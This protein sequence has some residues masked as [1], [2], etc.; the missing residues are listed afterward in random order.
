M[1]VPTVLSVVRLASSAS[2]YAWTAQEVR[3]LSA[4]HSTG[5][6]RC[7][8]RDF[9]NRRLHRRKH[10]TDSDLLAQSRPLEHLAHGPLH[11][12]H[13]DLHPRAAEVLED[14][15]E[16]RGSCDVDV[17]DGPRFESMS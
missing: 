6:H 10:A 12:C 1:L 15:L 14:L 5:V 2:R 8:G 11:F 7:L 4:A 3:T 16:N 9:G 13:R 17:C